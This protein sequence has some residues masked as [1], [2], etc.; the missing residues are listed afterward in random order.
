MRKLIIFSLVADLLLVALFFVLTR[1]LFS[2]AAFW[3]ISFFILSAMLFFE[4]YGKKTYRLVFIPTL[5]PVISFCSLDFV[6][7]FLNSS[8]LAWPWLYLSTLVA[9]VLAFRIFNHFVLESAYFREL[10]Y[11]HNIS[12][13]KLSALAVVNLIFLSLAILVII[14]HY[15]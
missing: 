12:R 4:H 2:T 8:I 1:W 15:E 14:D 11:S 13:R 3:V 9:C 6:G 5:L 10:K 7:W